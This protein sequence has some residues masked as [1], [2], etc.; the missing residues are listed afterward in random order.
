MRKLIQSAVVMGGLLCA[1]TAEGPEK[2]R[3]KKN[4][5]EKEQEEEGIR[6]PG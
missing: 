5:R 2:R 1:F 3:K 6:N 4:K